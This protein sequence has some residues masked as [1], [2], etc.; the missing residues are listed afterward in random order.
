MIEGYNAPRARAKC[1]ACG[2]EKHAGNAAA[3]YEGFVDLK[4]GMTYREHV[5]L[6]D[7][8]YACK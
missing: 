7:E 2:G 6:S 3:K 1:C 8:R 5:R 4:T